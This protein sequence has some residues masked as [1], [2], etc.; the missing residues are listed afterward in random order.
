MSNWI[1]D[2]ANKYCVT[3]MIH[4]WAGFSDIGFS[5]TCKKII[6]QGLKTQKVFKGLF[7]WNGNKPLILFGF[8]ILEYQ[9]KY[10]G[11]NEHL[12]QRPWAASRV[13]GQVK[14]PLHSPR[15]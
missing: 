3:Y 7:P 4:H 5:D 2:M 12:E 1:R 6:A 13:V 15:T 9:I 11:L 8:L 14:C 10:N